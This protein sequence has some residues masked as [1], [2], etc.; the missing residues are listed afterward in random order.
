MSTSAIV[1]VSELDRYISEIKQYPVLS[2]E[3]ETDLARRWRD[4][5][6]VQA[7][8]RLVTSNL[9][10]VVKIATEYRGYGMRVLDLIQEGSI[11]LMQAVKRFDPERGYRLLSYAV[12]W[13]RSY[14]HA[15]I[16][17]SMRMIKIGT[18]R[19]HRKLFFKLRSLKG[20]L[21]AGG[22]SDRDEVIDAV[23]EEVGVA[24]RDVEEMDRHLSGGDASIDKPLAQTGTAMV[25]VLPA[26]EPTQE[27]LLGELE[28]EADRA[29]L[30]SSAM[31]T[32]DPREREII[33]KRY[34]AE[35]QVQLKELG[36]QMGV[37]KQRIAQLERRALKKL[38]GQLSEAA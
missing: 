9:R 21:E 36:K 12:Y 19:A 27:E 10:F 28:A 14:M 4:S 13:I 3:E 23:A 11:G 30:L 32:L 6:D 22:M 20:K 15:Y 18:S 24:R 31:E 16:M 34:L 7:A 5:E 38:R 37:T 8:H 1:K 25:E 35:Q 26:D 17:G 33:E 2:H 29:A